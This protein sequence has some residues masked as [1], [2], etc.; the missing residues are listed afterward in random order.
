MVMPLPSMPLA[1]TLSARC[2]A[3]PWLV[4]LPTSVCGLIAWAIVPVS[5]SA[6]RLR[7]AE[8]GAKPSRVPCFGS[9]FWTAK[10]SFSACLR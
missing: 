7:T 3:T 9:T 4:A 10:P 6:A 8:S 2:S 1:C 5:S